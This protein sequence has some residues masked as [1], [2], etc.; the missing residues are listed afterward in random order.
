MIIVRRLLSSKVLARAL[1]VTV[2]AVVLWARYAQASFMQESQAVQALATVGILAWPAVVSPWLGGRLSSRS[3]YLLGL[4]GVVLGYW[5]LGQ[6]LLGFT[7]ERVLFNTTLLPYLGG[8]AAV[9]LGLVAAGSRGSAARLSSWLPSAALIVALAWT[10]YMII[11]IRAVSAVKPGKVAMPAL[12]VSETYLLA[13]PDRTSLVGCAFGEVL[14]ICGPDTVLLRFPDGTAKTTALNL[15][16]GSLEI[17]EDNGRILVLDKQAGAL[18]CF[19]AASGELAWTK[20]GLGTVNQAKWS[21]S[22]GWFLD[23]PELDEFDPADD[24][25]L[26]TR[27]DLKSGA[28]S[29]WTLMPPDG[30]FWPEISDSYEEGWSGAQL[31]LSGDSVFIRMEVRAAPTS[32]MRPFPVFVALPHEEPGGSWSLTR[33]PEGSGIDG[34]GV[35]GEVA[36]CLCFRNGGMEVVARDIGSGEEIWSLV[37]GGNSHGVNPIL[38]LPDRVLLDW[39]SFR[40]HSFRTDLVCLDPL[41]GR[42]VWRYDG[43]QGRLESMEP[44]GDMTLVLSQSDPTA[45]GG[46]YTDV[47]LL[48]EDGKPI[49][50]YKAKSPAYTMRIDA[51][52]G[53]LTLL[54]GA[55]SQL[56][57]SGW[58]GIE[59]VL[60]LSDGQIEGPTE[61]G[62]EPG[63]RSGASDLGNYRYVILDNVLYRS[64]GRFSGDYLENRAVMRLEGPGVPIHDLVRY[65]DSVLAGPDFIA[66]ACQTAQGVKVSV[67]KV[68]PSP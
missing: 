24:V 33:I 12:S 62:V 5:V 42:E 14:V 51:E 7:H 3:R 27:V 48:D 64:V 40:G 34:M 32:L 58:W 1:S 18:H 47:T 6:P 30:W 23:H 44:V 10:L 25:V 8:A 67:L 21:D 11:P 28:H 13:V 61:A 35:A 29:T 68:N 55:S 46:S 53:R 60:R 2:G 50:S 37:V 31:G 56:P 38:V 16:H 4:L 66:V 15:N 65:T 63:E 36:V 19:D 41:T 59:T 45:D 52:E 39:G 57:V 26:L 43:P 17:I 9:L 20:E 22:F 49:W 54:E